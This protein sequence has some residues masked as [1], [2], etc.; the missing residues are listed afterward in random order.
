M[1]YRTLNHAVSSASSTLNVVLSRI[2]NMKLLSERL[3]YIYA[4][5]PDLYGEKGQSGLVRASGATKSV[6][7]QWVNDKIKS[8]D[9]RYALNIERE[10]GFSHIWLMTGDGPPIAERPPKHD[11]SSNMGLWIETAEEMRVLTAYRIADAV[12]LSAFD[13]AT[14]LVLDRLRRSTRKQA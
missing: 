8:I 2:L 7:N 12:G 11:P 3:A 6:V 5:R 13:S 9:I 1:Q 4:Q 14:D 10:L